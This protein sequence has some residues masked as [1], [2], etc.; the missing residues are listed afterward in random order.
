[1]AR[2]DEIQE[3]QSEC[4]A[5]ER[6]SRHALSEDT[7]RG[8]KAIR[9]APVAGYGQQT[10]GSRPVRFCANQLQHIRAVPIPDPQRERQ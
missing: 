7:M 2:L 1:M 5:D 4:K 9:S 8:R 10:D 3:N 6:L